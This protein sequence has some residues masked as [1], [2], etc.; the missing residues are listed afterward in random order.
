MQFAGLLFSRLL[1][2][3]KWRYVDFLHASLKVKVKEA[4]KQAAF[5]DEDSWQAAAAAAAA[6][7]YLGWDVSHLF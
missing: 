2:S 3:N 6:P 1:G 4:R 7:S 5:L